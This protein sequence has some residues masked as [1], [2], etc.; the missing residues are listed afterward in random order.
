VGIIVAAGGAALAVAGLVLKVTE[1]EVAVSFV[2]TP[3]GG[4]L[5]V[6]GAW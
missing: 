5:V 4:A 6:G 3:G 2:P 1:P